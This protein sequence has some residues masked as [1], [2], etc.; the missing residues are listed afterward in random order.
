VKRRR[1]VFLFVVFLFGAPLVREY[2]P[3]GDGGSKNPGTSLRNISEREGPKRTHAR[4][5]SHNSFER[6]FPEGFSI[7]S[8]PAALLQQLPALGPVARV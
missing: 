7:L 4:K 2:V 1:R 3:R 8:L 5:F 6:F